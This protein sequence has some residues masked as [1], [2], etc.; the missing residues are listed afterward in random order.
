MVPLVFRSFATSSKRLKTALSHVY[1]NNN[2]NYNNNPQCSS[3]VRHPVRA[4]Q[5]RVCPGPRIL[6]WG[7]EARGTCRSWQVRAH[8]SVRVQHPGAGGAARALYLVL[9]VG[10]LQRG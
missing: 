10:A 7:H 5:A 1:N 9:Q 2:N 8:L 3:G 4:W 6:N